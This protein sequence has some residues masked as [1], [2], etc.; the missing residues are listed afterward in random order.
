MTVAGITG[1]LGAGMVPGIASG[2]G[3]SFGQRYGFERAYPAFQQGG[4]LQAVNMIKRDI[5]QL[6]HELMGASSPIDTITPKMIAEKNKVLKAIDKEINKKAKG[7]N[8]HGTVTKFQKDVKTGKIIPVSTGTSIWQ[9]R[10]KMPTGGSSNLSASKTRARAK[11]R[12]SGIQPR[13]IQQVFSKVIKDFG[14]LVTIH[15]RK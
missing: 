10:I 3:F 4:G 6:I 9:T 11:A 5:M 8:Y 12:K 15:Y 7:K 1:A 2:L 13:Q 14:Y